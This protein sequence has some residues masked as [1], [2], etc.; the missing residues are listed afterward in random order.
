MVRRSAPL[1]AFLMTSP[2]SDW[3]VR[4]VNRSA[5]CPS[6]CGMRDNI[7]S[8]IPLKSFLFTLKGVEGGTVGGRDYAGAR[9]GRRTLHPASSCCR[10]VTKYT[11]K[12]E[13]WLLERSHLGVE[14]LHQ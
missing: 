10:D 1:L 12:R 2:I 14:V 9:E 7:K 4:R 11:K 6:G 3:S 5:G 13:R 8:G